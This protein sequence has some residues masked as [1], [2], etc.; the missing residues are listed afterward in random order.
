MNEEERAAVEEAIGHHFER[1]ELVECA[2]THRSFR[3]HDAACT[4]N[5][6]LEFL[7]DAVLGLVVG[8]FLVRQFPE[9]SEGQLS[10]AR[11]RLASARSLGEAGRRLGLGRFLRLGPGEEKSG[12]REKGN[13]LANAYEALAAAVYLDQGLDAAAGFVRNSLIL[14]GVERSAELL[15]ASDHKSALQEWLQAR[16]LPVAEYRLVGESGPDH[17]K[18]FTIEV[19]AGGR[20]VA[21]CEGKSKKEAEQGAAAR[22]LERL[23]EEA[24]RESLAR[25]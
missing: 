6:M 1:P 24:E 2:L 20:V 19:E 3:A 12:G 15:A 4:H 11:A 5:E 10:K 9:W 18:S 25:G 14:P 8:D 16:G 21:R 23:H 17:A 7:G 13:L 22:A